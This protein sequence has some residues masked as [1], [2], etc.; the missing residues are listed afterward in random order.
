MS[1]LPT[2]D[3]DGAARA[4]AGDP[5]PL[6]VDQVLSMVRAGVLGSADHCE[7]LGGTLTSMPPQGPEHT[8]LIM[9]IARILEGHFGPELVGR[10]GPLEASQTSL[11]EPDVLVT[12]EPRR[13]DRHPLG[14]ECQLVV[15]VAVSSLAAD[16]AKVP[17]YAQAGVPTYWLLDVPGRRLTVYTDPLQ[18]GS[19]LE[20]HTLVDGEEVL[21]PTGEPVAVATLLG[22]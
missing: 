4:R 20:V 10:E 13:R 21:L 1:A 6:T 18:D 16:R 14:H 15:E 8:W 5:Y 3:P 19:W 17:I 11:P 12:A 2:H 22:G 9:H 7:L